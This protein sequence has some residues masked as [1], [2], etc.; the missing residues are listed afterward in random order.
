MKKILLDSKNRLAFTCL[1][2]ILGAFLKAYILNNYFLRENGTTPVGP[3][4]V[5]SI[6]YFPQFICL[7]LSYQSYFFLKGQVKFGNLSRVK[8]IFFFLISDL[9]IQLL[10]ANLF[11]N[12]FSIAVLV[13]IVFGTVSPFILLIFSFIVEKLKDLE[14]TSLHLFMKMWL[15]L[16]LFNLAINY[17][18]FSLIF[19]IVTEVISF[20][21]FLYWLIKED[22]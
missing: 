18:S 3:I 17:S 16:S 4:L 8:L 22:R 2:L 11:E 5:N 15:G 7:S 13:F 1:W 9:V 20:L 21:Y 6:I 19:F 14:K 10:L 12:T